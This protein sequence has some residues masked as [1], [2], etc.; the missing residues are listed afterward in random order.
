MVETLS[1]GETAPADPARDRLERRLRMAAELAEMGMDMARALHRRVLEAAAGDEAAASWDLGLAFARV[2][3]AVRLTLALEARLEQERQAR[4][5][6]IVAAQTAR[7]QAENAVAAG[8]AVRGWAR[9]NEVRDVVVEAIEAETGREHD[10]ERLFADLG[11]RLNREAD[12]DFADRPLGELVALI[13]RDLGLTPDWSLWENQAWAIQ[14]ARAQP[15]GSP[16]AARR[17]G[18]ARPE[19][20]EDAGESRP[21]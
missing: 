6:E 17:P 3:R 21:P 1:A 8:K 20:F 19:V 14:E 7:R 16:Y 4:D 10:I 11:E 5:Q 9:K 12:A 13:C 18:A 15:Q 2:S